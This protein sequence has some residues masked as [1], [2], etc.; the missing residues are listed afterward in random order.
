MEHVIVISPYFIILSLT[1]F[2]LS[3][4]FCNN[5]RQEPLRQRTKRSVNAST[6]CLHACRLSLIWF[7]RYNYPP[8]SRGSSARPA[9]L[10]H[11]QLCCAPPHSVR[12]ALLQARPM[13]VSGPQPHISST[14]PPR[15]DPHSHDPQATATYGWHGHTAT[16][17]DSH[18]WRRPTLPRLWLRLRHVCLVSSDPALAQSS[19][20]SWNR[21]LPT[22]C[23]HSCNNR[24]QEL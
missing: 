17:V 9:C 23:L 21:T 7:A 13:I 20:S 24:R 1:F 6:Q 2:S 18:P 15:L 10:L 14:R 3:L 12:I 5:R 22:G 8:P 4:F 19:A 16:L 11:R